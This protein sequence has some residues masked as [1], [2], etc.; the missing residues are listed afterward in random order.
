M[1]SA[2]SW[3][4]RYKSGSHTGSEPDP[5]LIRAIHYRHLLTGSA[6]LDLACGAGRHAA[7]LA[8]SGFSV[9]AIDF[10]QQALKLAVEKSQGLDIRF[11]ERDLESGN[12]DLGK[13]CYDLVAVFEYLHRPLFPAIARS[14]LPGGLVVYKTYLLGGAGAPSN[15]SY[16]LQPNELLRHFDGYRVLRY[17]EELASDVDGCATGQRATAALIAQKPE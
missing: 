12:P 15:P 4:E 5:L 16:L 8:R 17:Q 13:A 7:Y 11:L 3:N 6:A 9:T 2:E 14:I 10:S 1:A